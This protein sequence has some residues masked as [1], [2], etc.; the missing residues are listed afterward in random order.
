MNANLVS[1]AVV[2]LKVWGLCPDAYAGVIE[3]VSM[4]RGLLASSGRVQAIMKPSAVP[5]MRS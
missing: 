2:G 3:S 5:A 1:S 4:T